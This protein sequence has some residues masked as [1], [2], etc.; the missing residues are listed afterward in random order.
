MSREMTSMDFQSGL[1][2]LKRGH[3]IKQPEWGGFWFWDDENR[4]V[5]MF[6]RDGRV[7]DIRDSEDMDYTLSFIVNPLWRL[8][9]RQ[10]L[11]Q[12]CLACWDEYAV[13]HNLSGKGPR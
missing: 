5:Q 11:S 8:A 9:R 12:E 6:T 10:D 1:I 3:A 4:T 7:I 13:K 2:Y